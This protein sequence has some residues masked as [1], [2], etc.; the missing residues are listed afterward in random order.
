[1]N[2]ALT[3]FLDFLALAF[4]F[5]SARHVV[6]QLIVFSEP[7]DRDVTF[8]DGVSYVELYRGSKY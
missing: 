8:R 7:V 4:A 5:L 3:V 6:T 2:F 1:M